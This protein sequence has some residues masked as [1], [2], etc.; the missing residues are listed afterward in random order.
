MNKA[1][2]FPKFDIRKRTS[3]STKTAVR[4][5]VKKQLN[6][7]IEKKFADSA[8]SEVPLGYDSPILQV[9]TNLTQGTADA[10]QR[11]G[12]KARLAGI[13]GKVQVHART[14]DTVYRVMLVQWRDSNAG[15]S[16]PGVASFLQVAGTNLSYLSPYNH[17][18]SQSYTII[19]DK[20]I[21][22]VPDQ[23]NDRR[24]VEF[25]MNLANTK[26]VNPELQF[27]SGAQTGRNALYLIITSRNQ[28]AQGDNA[29][30]YIRVTYRD[31]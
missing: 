29:D 3:G 16:A 11:I 21:V 27:D 2:K 25:T 23:P 24:V 7:A 30:Y 12:D 4:R 9:L 26:F 1:P 6:R 15:A 5:E 20:N 10:F 31:A 14:A 28:V 8:G 19:W 18:N 17:D 13:H 22:A